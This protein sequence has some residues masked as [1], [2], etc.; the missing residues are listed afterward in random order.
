MPL[1]VLS[2]LCMH[3]IRFLTIVAV[4]LT[5]TENIKCSIKWH[6]LA[7]PLYGITPATRV[8]K[9][10]FVYV[11]R[12][13]PDGHVLAIVLNQKFARDTRLMFYCTFSGTATIVDLKCCGGSE[14]SSGG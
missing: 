5:V 6:S 7:R 4:I 8:V 12:Y 11:C 1:E 14:E 13:S 10:K 3:S 9:G 2:L